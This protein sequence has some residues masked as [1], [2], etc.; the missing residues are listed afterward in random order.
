MVKLKLHVKQ[1]S[2]LID[3]E[4]NKVIFLILYLQNVKICET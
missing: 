3:N 4:N 1:K 2:L